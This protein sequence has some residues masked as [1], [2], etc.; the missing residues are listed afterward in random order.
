MIFFLCEL[1]ALEQLVGKCILPLLLVWSQSIN[2][3]WISH[4]MFI[5]ILQ[6]SITQIGRWPD[7]E[8]LE[9]LLSKCNLSTEIL[10]VMTDVDLPHHLSWMQHNILNSIP[11]HWLEQHVTDILV[12]GSA[13]WMGR[14]QQG[15]KTYDWLLNLL[16]ENT[17]YDGLCVNPFCQ[18]YQ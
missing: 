4:L 18:F 6:I 10:R 5:N 11:V 13:I 12:V 8:V 15:L 7:N 3:V 17:C 2:Q 9:I 16:C 14:P 1:L